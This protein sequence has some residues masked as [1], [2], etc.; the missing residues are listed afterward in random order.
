MGGVTGQQDGWMDGE[1]AGVL[2]E[3]SGRLR[4][5][6]HILQ[7]IT[8]LLRLLPSAAAESLPSCPTLCDPIDGSP[9]GSSVP[10][11]LQARALECD[12]IAFS[13]APLYLLPML[14]KP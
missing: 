3:N 9:P 6:D 13:P 4:N 10:G 5:L 12:A 8:P 2:P 14:A 1:S 11:I 7:R